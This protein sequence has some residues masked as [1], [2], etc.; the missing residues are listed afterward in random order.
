MEPS[1]KVLTD[2]D[3]ENCS[4]L[5][6][7]IYKLMIQAVAIEKNTVSILDVEGIQIELNKIN[8]QKFPLSEMGDVAELYETIM[9]DLK[10][11][12]LQVKF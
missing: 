10:E 5:L 9:S 2:I 4:D 6:I 12:N 11:E 3:P 8:K 1:R 7:E